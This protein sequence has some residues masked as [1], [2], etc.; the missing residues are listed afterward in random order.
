MIG[1]DIAAALPRLRAEAES[2]MR[3][4]A[5]VERSAGQVRDPD[6]GQLIDD[7]QSVAEIPVHVVRVGTAAKRG[8]AAGQTVDSA[9]VEFRTKWDFADLHIGDR[10][11][12]TTG[13]DPRL[14]GVP[15]TVSGVGHLSFG[16]VSRRFKG[17]FDEDRQ[18]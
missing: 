7:W 13:G 4:T 5:V 9:D 16:A 14:Q 2:L 6:N 12:V 3:D 15:V 11:R 8:V 1:S 18:L 17:V 10:V